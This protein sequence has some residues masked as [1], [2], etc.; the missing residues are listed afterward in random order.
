MKGTIDRNSGCGSASVWR[1]RIA[2]EVHA[3]EVG[4]DGVRRAAALGDR[5]D[6]GRRADAH[7]TGAEHAGPAGR[8]RDGIGG[9]P[10]TL[11]GHALVAGLLDPVELRPLADREQDTVAGD[12]ELRPRGGLG[13]APAGRIGLAELHPDE[14]DAG[15]VAGLV[16][17]DAYRARLEDGAHTFL[18]RL[19]HFVGGGHVLHV[20]A[21]HE[22]HLGGALA[23][24]GPRAVHG[25]EPAADDDDAL[26]GVIRVR[27]PERRGPQVLEAV[28]HLGRVLAGDPQLVRVVAA[29]RDEDGAEA[30]VGQ[31]VEGEVAT[32]GRIAHDRAAQPRDRLVLGL[33]HLDLRQAVL[34]DAVAEHPAG[35]RVALED[36]HLVAGD[37]QVVGGG[38]AGGA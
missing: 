38:H 6:H 8:E 2:Y 24:R 5:L 18:D 12:R 26:A 11:R 29:D 1:V 16:G 37:Q 19:V 22:R 3:L 28:E 35:R 23:D 10:R 13:P 32:E 20:A 9:Q 21:V 25:G 4:V 34:R 7:V 17:D 33:E 27:Q 31:V 36:R 30:L 15:H 14:L